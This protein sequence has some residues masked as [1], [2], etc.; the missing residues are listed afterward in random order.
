MRA[1]TVYYEYSRKVYPN[2]P[3]F[4]ELYPNGNLKENKW[5]VISK[6]EFFSYN[7]FKNITNNKYTLLELL[8]REGK[9]V[10]VLEYR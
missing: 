5:E 8:V 1:Y 2:T 3:I 4:R 10:K 7:S 9:L 6:K